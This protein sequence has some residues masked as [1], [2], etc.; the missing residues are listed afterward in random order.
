MSDIPGLFPLGDDGYTA[1][2]R[3]AAVD[4]NSNGLPEV[5]LKVDAAAGDAGGYLVLY[6]LK[7]TVYGV[8]LGYRMFLDLKRDGTFSYS[9]PTGSEHGV[10]VLYLGTKDPGGLGKRFYCVLDHETDQYTYYVRRQEATKAEYAAAEAQ[11]EE[12]Q[13]AIWYSFTPADIRNVFP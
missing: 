1:V 3:F 4:L 5:V 6:Q 9:D 8:K 10:A 13:D 2:R 7:G 12:Q 11:W